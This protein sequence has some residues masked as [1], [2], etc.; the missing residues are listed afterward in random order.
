MDLDTTICYRAVKSRDARFDGR[1]FTGVRTTG[2]YCRPVCPAKTP[3]RENVEF[4]PCAAAAEAAGFRPCLRC[5]PEASPGTPAWSG[6]SATVS[7]A[8]RMIDEGFLDENSLEDLATRLGVGT[9]H[10][11]RLFD[12]HLGSSPLAVAQS[13]RVL[14]AKHLIDETTLPITDIAFASGFQS[15]R[16]FNAAFQNVYRRSPRDIRRDTRNGN[17]A[18]S[19]DAVR[20]RLAYRPP[21]DWDGFMRFIA[22]RALPHVEQAEAGVYRRTARIG[23]RAGVISVSH[24]TA[25]NHLMLSVPPELTPHL[26][27]IAH[28]VRRMFDLRADPSAVA[29]HLGAVPGMGPLVQRRSG[30][31]VP[32]AWD[33]FEMAV[34]AVIGQQISVAGARTL[35]GRLVEK[36]G[37]PLGESVPSGL[38]YVFPAPDR[39]ARA[40]MNG[41][42]LTQRRIDTI[43]ALAKAVTSGTWTWQ[44]A[45]DL[46]DT[47]D[48]LTE[49]P[50]IG[51]WTAQYIAMRALSEPD[52]FPTGDLGLIKAWSQIAGQDV[53]PK[54]LDTAA[55]AWRPWRAYATLHL[56]AGL[57]EG[58]LQ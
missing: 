25:R 35:C 7:R 36:Y 24:D 56:W 12:T 3:K 18:P 40:R 41:I 28:R 23:E 16:R 37:E 8:L 6:T 5:R 49:L 46:D 34:R 32:G 20:L 13:R 19:G 47:V 14:F 57:A 10:L 15:V 22:D 9:R 4:F 43:R 42:G 29:E 39:L 52:A 55:E 58:D 31:R 33:P 50:G 1:F 54:E 30:L 53:T 51:P 26:P 21:F 44:G 27:Q 38:R 48:R 11:R 2:V 17:G 45:A